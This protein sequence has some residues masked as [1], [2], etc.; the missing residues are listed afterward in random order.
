MDYKGAIGVPI[1]FMD[2]YNPDQF[3]IVD[4]LN[5]YSILDGPTTKTRGKYLAQINGKPCYVRIVIKNKKL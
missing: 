2:K 4:G 5:R 3:E 1:T